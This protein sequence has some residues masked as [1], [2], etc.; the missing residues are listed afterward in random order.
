[1]SAD[2]NE[3]I[4]VVT[5]M[6]STKGV[7]ISAITESGFEV[8]ENNGGTS[9]VNLNWM[10]STKQKGTIEHS[11]EIIANDFETKMNGLMTHDGDPNV[12]AQ[13]VWWDGT[14]IRFDAPN[15]IKTPVDPIPGTIRTAASSSAVNE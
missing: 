7:Y 4:V 15:V 8:T 9:S 2:L 12:D 3:M 11:N 5:P 10:V 6:G 14:D 13:P 1:M